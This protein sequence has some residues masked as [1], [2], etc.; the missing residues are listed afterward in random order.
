VCECGSGSYSLLVEDE[1]IFV[2]GGQCT[3]ESHGAVC[4]VEAG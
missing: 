2:V 4:G 1:K 3:R